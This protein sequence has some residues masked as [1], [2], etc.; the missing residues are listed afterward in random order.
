[1]RRWAAGEEG[2]VD[3]RD[4]GS[5]DDDSWRRRWMVKKVARDP[6]SN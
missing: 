2:N 5:G 3:M 4:G 6:W 1:V